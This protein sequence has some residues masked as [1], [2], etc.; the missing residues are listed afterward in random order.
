MGC[1][2]SLLTPEPSLFHFMYY[3]IQLTQ[4]W[5]IQYLDW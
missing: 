3:Y 2:E 5:F 1:E 4:P